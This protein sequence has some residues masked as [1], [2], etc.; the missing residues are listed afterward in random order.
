MFL[1]LVVA[2]FIIHDLLL[3]SDI[4]MH[5][6]EAGWKWKMFKCSLCKFDNFFLQ[7]YYSYL[8]FC[9]ALNSNIVIDIP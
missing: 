9:Q 5:Y 6:N 4:T 3:L 7:T 1:G 2:C 8:H